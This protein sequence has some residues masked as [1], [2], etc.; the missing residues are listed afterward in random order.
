MNI[1]P[2]SIFRIDMHKQKSPLLK[3]D[4]RNG[5]KS[6]VLLKKKRNVTQFDTHFVPKYVS[7]TGFGELIPSEHTL[8]TFYPI[9]PHAPLRFPI[10]RR[11][12]NTLSHS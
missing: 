1:N 3:N 5:T 2:T 10:T 11:I 7:V 9:L 4:T 12:D 6:H 8:F